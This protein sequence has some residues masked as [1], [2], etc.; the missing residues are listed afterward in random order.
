MNLTTE[1]AEEKRKQVLGEKIFLSLFEL[2]RFI[3]LFTSERTGNQKKS[4]RRKGRAVL[5][6]TE[7]NETLI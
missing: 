7:S 2:N 3:S 1:E 4:L 6:R 5:G